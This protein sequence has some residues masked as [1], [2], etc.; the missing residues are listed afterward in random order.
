MQW[1]V[2]RH[3]ADTVAVR[4]SS[5]EVL[6]ELKLPHLSEGTFLSPSLYVSNTLP[7]LTSSLLTPAILSSTYS[8]CPRPTLKLAQSSSDQK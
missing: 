7:F 6:L 2:F 5:Y 3:R 1:T 8:L 4:T